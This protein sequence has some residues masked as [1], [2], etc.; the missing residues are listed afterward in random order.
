MTL[1][2]D[3]L[4]IAKHVFKLMALATFCLALF[5]LLYCLLADMIH[6]RGGDDR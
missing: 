6:G 4:E 1:P 2:P 3:T 5:W